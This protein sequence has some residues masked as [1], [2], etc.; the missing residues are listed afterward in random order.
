MATLFLIQSAAS[1]TSFV[2]HRRDTHFSGVGA[3]TDG[4]RRLACLIQPLHVSA[5]RRRLVVL[6][7]CTGRALWT[8]NMAVPQS[9][10]AQRVAQGHSLFEAVQQVFGQ[11]VPGAG[12]TLPVLQNGLHAEPQQRLGLDVEDQQFVTVSRSLVR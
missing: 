8:T 2:S 12:Q 7:V 11:T 4:Q 10:G 9:S 6:S 5:L 3:V 1:L